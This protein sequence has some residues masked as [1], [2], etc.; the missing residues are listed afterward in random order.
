MSFLFASL[1]LEQLGHQS[2]MVPPRLLRTNPH[3]D[4]VPRRAR[5]LKN[6]DAVAPITTTCHSVKFNTIVLVWH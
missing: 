2:N 1:L 3:A 4:L 5:I 6:A